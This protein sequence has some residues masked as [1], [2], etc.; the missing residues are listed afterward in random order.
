LDKLATMSLA[1]IIAGD[2][3]VRLDRPSNPASSQLT[4]LLSACGLSCRVH[5]PTLLGELLDVVATRDDLPIPTVQV[6]DVGLSDHHMLCWLMPMNRPAPVY[7]VYVI[8]ASSMA[9]GEH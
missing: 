4:D 7:T 6:I 5:E 2:L 3:N 1:L 9:H 8:R